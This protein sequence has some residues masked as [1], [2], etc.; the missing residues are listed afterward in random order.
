MM[1]S[2][3]KT[4]Q[5]TNKGLQTVNEHGSRARSLYVPA[6]GVELWIVEIQIP[7]SPPTQR[8]AEGA[9]P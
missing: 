9:E 4:S 3:L 1:T 6:K 7:G 5:K 2:R 8:R